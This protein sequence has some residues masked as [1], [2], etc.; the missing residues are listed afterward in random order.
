MEN[1]CYDVT[2]ATFNAIS[3]FT[4]N[5]RR[6]SAFNDMASRYSMSFFGGALGGAIFAGVDLVQN[7]K[8]SE[9]LNQENRITC[10]ILCLA[11][12]T[13]LLAGNNYLLEEYLSPSLG[14]QA[15]LPVLLAEYTFRKEQDIQDYMKLLSSVDTYFQGI[16][17]FEKLK[18]VIADVLNVDPDEITMET[19]FVDDL[20]A[21]SLDVFQII[22]GLEE[23]FDIEIPAEDAEKITTVEEAVNLIKNAVNN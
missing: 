16:M 19:T 18:K 11:Y 4:G 9:Q 5:E 14:T 13:E 21:D 7:G 15:Q 17:E 6:L 10:D 20:G 22:M 8:N 23:E 2:K 12:E 1:L 3:Y